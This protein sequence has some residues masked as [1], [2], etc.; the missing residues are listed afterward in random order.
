M[1]QKEMRDLVKFFPFLCSIILSSAHGLNTFTYQLAMALFGFSREERWPILIK[2]MI[3]WVTEF[4][5][6]DS[7]N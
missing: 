2:G 5:F 4:L 1:M 7:F 6:L 3:S